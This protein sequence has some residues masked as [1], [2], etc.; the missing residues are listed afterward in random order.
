MLASLGLAYPAAMPAKPAIVRFVVD[1]LTPLGDPQKAG[2]QAAYMKT[3]QPFFGVMQA[4][5]VPVSREMCERFAPRNFGE[6]KRNALALWDAGRAKGG[7]RDLQYAAIFYLERFKAYHTPALLPLC[8]R[9]VE[10]GAWWDLVDWIATKLVSP[11]VDK[12]RRVAAPAMRKWIEDPH[13]WVRRT[14][15][16][17]QLSNK[18][19]ADLDML[20]G[21]CL[22]RAEEKDFFIRK[23]IGWALR[24]HSKTHPTEIRAFLISH[25]HRFSNLSVREGGKHIGVAPAAKKRKGVGK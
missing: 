7:Q 18:R 24:D 25:K 23:A 3:E 10:Q 12:H 16:L 22:A 9:L 21:F 17:S 13:L 8:K 1:R 15:I 14:A 4:L 11:I 2:D 6:Y 19:E 20:F 5:R